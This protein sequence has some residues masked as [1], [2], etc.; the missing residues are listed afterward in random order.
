MSV[1]G[2]QSGHVAEERRQIG[3]R[4]RLRTASGL[5]RYVGDWARMVNSPNPDGKT[6]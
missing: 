6:F 4:D 2:E 5:V 1:F 3:C